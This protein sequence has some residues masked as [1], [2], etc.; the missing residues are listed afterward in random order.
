MRPFHRHRGQ[1][2]GAAFGLGE[3]RARRAAHKWEPLDE[4]TVRDPNFFAAC[5]LLTD[6]QGSLLYYNA[7]P[8][9]VARTTLAETAL[10]NVRRLRPDAGETHLA[11]AT[12]FYHL[13]PA[14]MLGR[15]V[16]FQALGQAASFG[17]RE[18]R[19]SAGRPVG[20]EP[21]HDQ[22]DLFGRWGEF[23]AGRFDHGGK[24]GALA[25]ARARRRGAFLP[26]MHRP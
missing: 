17:G 12:Y 10:A 8:T 18:S 5:C 25:A 24:V 22:H 20:V 7:D 2:P 14:S 6:V 11:A 16:D 15:V 13:Q 26:G 23:V 1:T 4:A 3:S 9:P 19:L 21:I